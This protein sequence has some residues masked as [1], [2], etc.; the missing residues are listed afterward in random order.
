VC[1]PDGCD[2][3]GQAAADVAVL[4][5]GFPALRAVVR[6]AEGARAELVA[7]TDGTRRAAG[8]LRRAVPA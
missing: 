1:R 8:E 6:L 3:A 2:P 4:L 7:E 5:A